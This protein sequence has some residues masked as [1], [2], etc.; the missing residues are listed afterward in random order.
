MDDEDGFS[1]DENQVFLP[2]VNIWNR[3]SG[4]D[5]G[6]GLGGAI[7]LKKGRF[8]L[9]EKFKLF[10]LLTINVINELNVQDLE[11]ISWA[12]KIHILSLAEKIP[13]FQYKNSPAFVLGYMVAIRSNYKTLDIDKEALNTVFEINKQLKEIEDEIIIFKIEEAD[14]LRYT[15]LCLLNKIK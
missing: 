15:R 2:E 3:L 6:L 10:V 14:I 4:A 7:D 8:T 11:D 9:E 12:E 1:D 13:D 5:I